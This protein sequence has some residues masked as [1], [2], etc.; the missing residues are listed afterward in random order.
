MKYFSLKKSHI[1]DVYITFLPGGNYKET[2]EKASSLIKKGFNYTGV[3][4]SE[5]FVEFTKKKLTS[6]KS[7]HNIV[8]GDMKNID[9]KKKYRIIFIGLNSICHLLTNRD[10]SK[11]FN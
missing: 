6:I 8:Q 2:V 7:V 11:I 9:L 5:T 1:L 10:L 3:E 4:L